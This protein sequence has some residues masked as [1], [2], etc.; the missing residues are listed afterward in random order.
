MK[1]AVC[2][3]L[4][5]SLLCL[6]SCVSFESYYPSQNEIVTLYKNNRRLFANAAAAAL[7]LCPDSYVSTTD[8]Y[9]PAN[10]D[11]I[12]GLYLADR[13]DKAKEVV[14]S[15]DDRDILTLF[16]VCGVKSLST[17][18]EGELAG[19]EFSCGGSSNIYCGVYYIS[20][21]R[22]VF[23]SDF[24]AELDMYENGWKYEGKYGSI[25]VRY[26]TEKIA[27]NFYYYDAQ[28]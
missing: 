1:K 27:D 17:R 19:V 20:E 6:S 4:A 16:E 9:R 28:A 26:Y 2:L 21:D 13:T 14:T 5:L 7:R 25:S 8:Y 18:T 23:L 24:A 12:E 11:G 3:F 22:P 15:L 10:S